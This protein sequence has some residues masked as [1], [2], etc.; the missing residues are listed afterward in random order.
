MFN[1]IC[2]EFAKQHGI[3]TIYLPEKEQ[4]IGSFRVEGKFKWY[5][6]KEIDGIRYPF[7]LTFDTYFY[8]DTSLKEIYTK[9]EFPFPKK[10][11]IEL[12]NQFIEE[13][14]TFFEKYFNQ[15]DVD[16][17]R[18][19][20]NG[21]NYQGKNIVWKTDLSKMMKQLKNMNRSL[22]DETVNELHAAMVKSQ[23]EIPHNVEGPQERYLIVFGEKGRQFGE[24]LENTLMANMKELET[25]M[26]VIEP[27]FPF[28]KGAK[29]RHLSGH[30]LL[31]GSP[32]YLRTK[33]VVCF[34]V[35]EDE[36]KHYTKNESDE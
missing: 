6:Y 33:G 28:I 35:T 1:E 23:L 9:A 8:H 3:E 17:I 24:K 14:Q 12:G 26:Y 36:L 11:I 29:E 25:D 16:R 21:S 18:K 7:S 13:S 10:E 34:V 19:I 32:K 4:T 31:E 2:E 20:T 30:L 27:L 5:F 15:L 22:K